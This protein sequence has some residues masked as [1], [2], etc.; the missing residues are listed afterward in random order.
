[1]S[2]KPRT[3]RPPRPLSNFRSR[4]TT[5][6]VSV[7]TVCVAFLGLTLMLSAMATASSREFQNADTFSESVHTFLDDAKFPGTSN[8]VY[9]Y[10]SRRNPFD[11]SSYLGFYNGALDAHQGKWGIPAYT[12]KQLLAAL[13]DYLPARRGTTQVV[14]TTRTQ[15][16]VTVLPLQVKGDQPGALVLVQDRNARLWESLKFLWLYCGFAAL[17]IILLYIGTRI[18]A[19]VMLGSLEQMVKVSQATDKDDLTQRMPV[20]STT[21]L[22]IV[23]SSFNQMLDRLETSLES[24]RNLMDDVGHELRTPITVVSGHLQVMNSHDP[25]QIERVKELA[26]EE[27]SRMERLTNDVTTMAAAGRTGYF[28]SEPIDMFDLAMNVYQGAKVLG[29]RK[30]KLGEITPLVYIGDGQRIQQAWMALVSNAVKYSEDSSTIEIGLTTSS[31]PPLL[32]ESGQ[33]ISTKVIRRSNSKNGA[34]PTWP[35]HVHENCGIMRLWVRD[36]G[37]GIPEDSQSRVFERYM[38]ADSSRPGSGLGLAVV[39][40]IATAHGGFLELRSREG[41]GSVFA[42]ALPTDTSTADIEGNEDE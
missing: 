21:E 12:D 5:L 37:I 18:M 34:N 27:L 14:K 35:T 9:G 17:S 3:L 30:W 28:K 31:C 41:A 24:Q 6:T 2:H 33:E 8:A 36:N 19:G 22:S 13:H 39:T 1:M 16:L 29:K 25:A 42:I 4:I 23:A 20:S 7:A 15:Y 32:D 38:R 11:Y 26:L 10:L 40:A